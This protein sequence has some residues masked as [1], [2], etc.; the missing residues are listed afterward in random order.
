MSAPSSTP[1]PPVEHP[2]AAAA[3]ATPPG[4]PTPA[5]KR[6]RVL[7]LRTLLTVPFVLLIVLPAVIIAGTLLYTGLRAVD[8]LSRQLMDDISARVGQAA[9]HQLEEAAVTLRSTFPAADDNFNASIDLFTDDERLERKLFELTAEARTTSYLYFGRE[10]GS[11]VG[12][13]RGRPGARAAATVRL[14]QVGGVPRT[15]Y[16][17]RQ[18]GDRTRLIETENRVYDARERIWYRLAKSSL[19]LTWAPVY[20]SFASGALVTTAAQPVISQSG[21]LYGVLAAD[22]ELAELSNFMKSVAVSANGVAFI[23]DH[24][25]MLVASSTTEAPFR[26]EGG[27]QKRVA[28]RDSESEL[29]RESSQWWRGNGRNAT[30]WPAIASINVGGERVD[31][32]SRRVSG[33][34]GIDWDIVVAVP[35]SDVTAPIVK[36]ALSMFVVILVALAAALMLGLWVLRRVTH[37]VDL[38]VAATRD[39]SSNGL[40]RGDRAVTTLAETGVLADAFSDMVARLRQ[41]LVTIG[42]QNERFA[43][44]NATLEHR[45]ERRTTQL[46]EQNLTLTEEIIRRERLE[47][48]LRQATQAAEKAA[49]DKARFLAILSHELR[50][51]LQAVVGAGYL[52]SRGNADGDRG[53]QVAI[54]EAASKSLLTLIDGVLSYS[55]LE[56]GVVTPVL[57]SFA[58]REC[59]DEASRIVRAAYDRPEVRWLVTVDPAV[60]TRVHTDAGMLRQVLVNLLGN[61]LKFTRVGAIRLA[62]TLDAAAGGNDVLALRFEVRDDG[63][64][65]DRQTQQRLFQP[66]QQGADA[67]GIERD[68]DGGTQ[69]QGSGLGLV[70][71]SLL[72]KALGGTI[73]M[74]SEPGQGTTMTFTVL[75]QADST[76]GGPSALPAE[77]P[78]RGAIA[79]GAATAV[80][81]AAATTVR[82]AL[83]VL[84]VEDNDVNRELLGIMLRELGHTVSGAADGEAAIVACDAE[85]FD[86]V[87]MDLNL[88]RL[89]GLEATRRILRRYADRGTLPTAPVVVALTASVS[90]ADRALCAAAGMR[91]FLS[92]PATVFSLDQALREALH[93]RE[94]LASPPSSVPAIALLDLDTLS[95]LVELDARAP[96]PFLD[97]LLRRFLDRLPDDVAGIVRERQAGDARA[98]ARGAHA[99]A[100]AASAVGAVALARAARAIS[101]APGSGEVASLH[102]LADA[103]VEAFAQWHARRGDGNGNGG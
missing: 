57:G 6:R 10:N 5:P 95:S 1:A 97:R 92:K 40:P 18:P 101:E 13:D 26:N 37:D 74:T 17:S 87:L 86:V 34:E 76:A 41:S 24:E 23:L 71:C 75:A 30:Q 93:Q 99:L 15:I 16:S 78:A 91:G 47:R 51:P 81:A 19:R 70:I 96:E 61:A 73:T 39:V 83:H 45:V 98:V 29:V 69:A 27:V 77:R 3:P 42:A 64:G 89:G 33:I 31:V 67:T 52:L 12:V 49:A 43:Q 79:A 63:P 65:I 14:Q 38:L 35:R 88:P 8:V 2:V 80:V 102:A 25:G 100:G 32:A 56:A 21:T 4:A 28:A 36:N 68:A 54:I 82:R 22:V 7:H 48:D 58:L 53:E 85:S 72:V 60:P 94:A 62:V 44:L 55:R 11:F 9:V 46:G 103:T 66:F 59:I 90:E 84:V 20:V 50:T